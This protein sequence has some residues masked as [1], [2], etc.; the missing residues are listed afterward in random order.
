MAE[1][2][3]HMTTIGLEMALPALGGYWLDRRLGTL[4]VFLMIG[5][6]LGF[7]VGMLHLLQLAKS[8]NSRRK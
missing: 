8:I 5:L 3:S 4:P 7:V 2:S 1:W 6:L